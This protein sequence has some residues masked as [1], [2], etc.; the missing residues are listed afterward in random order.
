M[1]AAQV[2]VAAAAAA[3]LGPNE[4]PALAAGFTVPPN[5]YLPDTLTRLSLVNLGTASAAD[6]AEL[7]LW[8]DGGDGVF[9]AG[10]GDDQDLGPLSGSS[11]T[12]TSAPL[13][14]PVS[15]AGERLWVS[16]VIAA[17]PTDS[18]TIDLRLPVGGL[19]NVSANDGP[20]DAA[21]DLGPTLTISNAP[22]ISSVRIDP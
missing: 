19:T 9:G 6:V 21:V 15:L 14:E 3:T 10:G 13:S 5:G 4:G 16:A 2:R 22:L 1:V 18:A 8:R 17:A 11:G 7:R 20:L 12:W